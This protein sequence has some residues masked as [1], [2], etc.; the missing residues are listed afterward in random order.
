MTKYKELVAFILDAI[1][2]VSDDAFIT[3]DHVIF[4]LNKYRSYLLK[5]KYEKDPRRQ[6]PASNYQS[7][8]LTLEQYGKTG[9][10]INPDW[11]Y[12]GLSKHST[13]TESEDRANM[14]GL[15]AYE[16]DGDP[17]KETRWD[18]KN[19]VKRTYLRSTEQLPYTMQL[20]I[21]SCYIVDPFM[22]TITMISKERLEFVGWNK[23]LQKIIYG[24]IGP[25]RR[26]YIK[27]N[28]PEFLAIKKVIFHGILED[29]T[30]VMDDAMEEDCPI[31]EALVSPLIKSVIADLLQFEYRPQDPAN[32]ANDDLSD[33]NL[34][35]RNNMKKSYNRDYL[36]G[37]TE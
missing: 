32:N 4:L 34:F 15:I 3:E 23:F 35:I 29:P 9:D 26:L 36:D 2:A 7:I 8:E 31:E 30:S 17:Q 27:S 16:Q 24:A 12:D 5:Q 21:S 11:D 1:K 25:D 10:G 13:V 14:D 19:L 28:N 22:A 37:E 33:I 20:G 18:D 6:V